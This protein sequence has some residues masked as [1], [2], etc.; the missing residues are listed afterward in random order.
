[1]MGPRLTTT[2][3][4]AAPGGLFAVTPLRWGPN[5][6]PAILAA[7]FV[8]GVIQTSVFG[9]GQVAIS[10]RASCGGSRSEAPDFFSCASVCSLAP[11]ANHCS[12]IWL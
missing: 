4:E 6:Y 12:A 8:G 11:A 5:S 10:T 1:M 3:P 7:S 9:K 2:A